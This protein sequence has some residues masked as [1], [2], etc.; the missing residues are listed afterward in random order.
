MY[1]DRERFEA[2]MERLL[3]RLEMIERALEKLTRR[4]NMLDG[5][6]LY[7]NQDLC[8]LLNISK[9]TLQR[10]RSSGELPY[11]TIYHKT[12][13]RESDIHTFIRTNFDKQDA[14]KDGGQPDDGND[15]N[16]DND[17]NEDNG[18]ENNETANDNPETPCP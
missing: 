8:Q 12:Y 3:E 10:Y 6:R 4:Q 1:I 17:G 7:D 11:H 18:H 14:Q 16:H 15:E 13:Y 9:R 5:E 2:W